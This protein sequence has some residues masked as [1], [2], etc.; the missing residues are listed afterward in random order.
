MENIIENNKIIVE[1]MGLKP[2]MESPDIYVFNDMPYFSVRENNPEDVMNAIVKYSKYNSDWNWL[3]KVVEKIN[4]IDEDRFTVQIFSMDTYI[5]DSKYRNFII[6]TELTY[7][8][9]ELIKSVYNTC[10][11]FIKWYNSHLCSNC[12]RFD[13]VVGTHNIDTCEECALNN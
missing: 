1:F 8:P 13:D 4:T 10:V 2:K 7:N 11:K 12:G 5:Y 9:D 6:K 3:M